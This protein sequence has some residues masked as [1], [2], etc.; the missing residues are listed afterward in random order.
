MASALCSETCEIS[1]R[2]VYNRRLINIVVISESSFVGRSVR[3]AVDRRRY[4]AGLSQFCICSCS[5]SYLI[6]L[7]QVQV[8]LSVYRDVIIM[9]AYVQFYSAGERRGRGL[10]QPY[11]PVEQLEKTTTIGQIRGTIRTES[12]NVLPTPCCYCYTVNT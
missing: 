5:L 4:L 9:L 8:L 6:T 3:T 1:N 2:I 11:I 7:Y 10:F 12:E